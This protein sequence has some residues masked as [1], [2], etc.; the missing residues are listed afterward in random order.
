MSDSSAQ[1]KGRSSEIIN[2][3]FD[4]YFY[5]TDNFSLVKL[6]LY[7][8]IGLSLIVI[9][10]LFL[11]ILNLILIFSPSLKNNSSFVQVICWFLGI[12]VKSDNF[13]TNTDSP[14]IYVSNHITCFDYLPLKSIING[15]KY[16]EDTLMNRNVSTKHASQDL[17]STFFKK[18]LQYDAAKDTENLYTDK[19]EFPFIFFPEL[20][21]T[22]GKYGVLKFDSKPFDL[23]REE[24]QVGVVPVAIQARRPI[25]SLS[26]NWLGS[27]DLINI[28]FMM[29]TPYTIYKVR[30]LPE[31]FL[32]EN[33]SSEQFASRVQKLIA[34]GLDIVCSNLDGENIRQMW[35][36]YEKNQRER[37][38]QA[39]MLQNAQNQRQETHFADVSR[40]ALQVKNVLPYVTYDKI[41]EHV[42]LTSSNDIDTII[43]SILD[44]ECQEP[45]QQPIQMEPKKVTSEKSTA[46][47]NTFQS[48]ESRKFN[49]L[50]EARNRFLAKNPPVN[51]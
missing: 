19:N 47:K 40:V 18:T 45:S 16:L 42:I 43:T 46:K 6:M 22:N 34:N 4:Q 7:T 29:F 21:A 48:F 14:R 3:Y 36:D 24:M 25:F 20:M 23:N 44:S 33:E 1:A 2:E 35:I 37:Q 8:P 5:K 32:K 41:R 39:D 9:R 27:N 13:V 51:A 30:F 38:E 26:L 31:Q 17:I 12:I 11:A 49:L 15:S 50:N 10:F 28:L